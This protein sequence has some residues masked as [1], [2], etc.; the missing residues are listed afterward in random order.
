[1]EGWRAVSWTCKDS[2]FPDRLYRS[3]HPG[4]PRQRKRG[5]SCHW[6]R[7]ALTPH[8]IH[9]YTVK[10]GQSRL[11]GRYQIANEGMG[12]KCTGVVLALHLTIL[13]VLLVA[14]W[15][16]QCPAI[17][18]LNPRGTSPKYASN[19]QGLVHGESVN[20]GHCT[21]KS[22]AWLATRWE[23][24]WMTPQSGSDV[25]W[26]LRWYAAK[27]TYANSQASSH[28]INR[29][30]LVNW[31]S[32]IIWRPVHDGA[33]QRT[34]KPSISIVTQVGNFQK[35]RAIHN[36]DSSS[37]PLGL[38]HVDTKSRMSKSTQ[39]DGMNNEL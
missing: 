23:M 30:W 32:S 5:S 20:A 8:E 16:W 28:Q 4:Q 27:W 15:L 34:S 3:L 17:Q 11:A 39:R 2:I 21:W 6:F 36:L 10:M 29:T 14:E 37:R 9:A 18:R 1:M 26:L 24:G 38:L 33:F 7:D 22:V 25:S 31:W 12:R 19:S 35:R 13:G